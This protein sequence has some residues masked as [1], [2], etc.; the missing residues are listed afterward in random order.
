[1]ASWKLLPIARSVT[2]G[3]SINFITVLRTRSWDLLRGANA[4]AS[5]LAAACLDRRNGASRAW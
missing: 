3:S 1:M 4:E 5:R 2:C